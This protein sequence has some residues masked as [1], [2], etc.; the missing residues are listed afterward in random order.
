MT[1]RLT[2]RQLAGLELLGHW[3]HGLGWGLVLLWHVA[4][5]V[6]VAAAGLV[7]VVGW[8]GDRQ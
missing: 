8:N 6:A 7:S 5:W 2:P 3:L 1:R 4:C